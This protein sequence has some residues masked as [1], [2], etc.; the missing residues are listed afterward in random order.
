M[1]ETISVLVS[2][3]PGKGIFRDDSVLPLEIPVDRLKASLTDLVS[4]L[5]SATAEITSNAAAFRL[6]EMEVGIEI[7]SEGGVNLIGTMKVGGNASL[8]LIFEW[9]Q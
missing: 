6:K 7:T 2:P 4:K 8:R 9:N 3:E 1:N 5:V